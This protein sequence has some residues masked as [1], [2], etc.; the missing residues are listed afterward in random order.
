V[1]PIVDVGTT[2]SLQ[3]T[4]VGH[5]NQD[6]CMNRV[7]S[8]TT[9]TPRTPR[10]Q[11][12]A[13]IRPANGRPVPAAG[14]RGA[15]ILLART[16]SPSAHEEGLH[17]RP[18]DDPIAGT[19]R[20]ARPSPAFAARTD[21]ACGWHRDAD[22]FRRQNDPRCLSAAGALLK[23]LVVGPSLLVSWAAARTA[24]LGLHLMS[25]TPGVRAAPSWNS[26][27]PGMCAS[28]LRVRAVTRMRE[29]WATSR[30]ALASRTR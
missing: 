26:P 1:S 27:P 25:P 21:T 17:R 20:R 4:P 14:C 7:R 11:P 23:L 10:P 3:A 22:G 13:Q 16:P 19:R 30:T 12:S 9:V 29:H 5:H 24:A 6:G 28:G 15:V 18:I 2:C 8:S